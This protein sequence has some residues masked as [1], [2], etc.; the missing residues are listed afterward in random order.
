MPE[1]TVTIKEVARSAGVSVGTVSRVIN[2]FDNISPD[3]LHKVREAMQSLGYEKAPISRA[4]Q[5]SRNGSRKTGNVGIYFAT[6]A[7]DWS[8]HPLFAQYM[9][10]IEEAC[11]EMAY[12]PVVEFA[13]EKGS[14]DVPRFIREGKVDALLVKGDPIHLGWLDQL[15]LNMPVVGLAMQ[16]PTLNLPQVMPDNRSAGWQ[17]AAHLWVLG[18][19]RIATVMQQAY[20]HMFLSRRHGVEEF[21]RRQQAYD[22]TLDICL[23][24]PD[25]VDD[26]GISHPESSP[27]DL[28]NLIARLWAMPVNQRPTAIVAVNDWTAA[29][30]YMAMFKQG[31]QVGKDLSIVGIDND[32]NACTMLNP[33]LT[34]FAMPF[35]R[36]AYVAVRQLIHE[37]QSP[38]DYVPAGIQLVTGQI[39]M[40]H[41][42]ADLCQPICV[43]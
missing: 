1:K 32:Q 8:G 36:S 35:A 29:G 22:P 42:V 19:R 15:P 10:G 25:L 2:G 13:D 24:Q 9:Q 12:H 30:L 27:P 34:S 33:G 5:P 39:V 16:D 26:E 11:L 23:E 14:D 28:E 43:D 20:H 18:H 37:L 6:M 41:S 40:R 4:P 17:M 3:N 21:L 7:S 31:L 38:L